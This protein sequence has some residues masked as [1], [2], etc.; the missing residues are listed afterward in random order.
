MPEPFKALGDLYLSVPRSLF[1]QAVEAYGKAIE[2]RPFY[3]DAYAG[4]GDANA[5]KGDLDRAVIAYQ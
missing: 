3:A 1:D 2:L 4:L 5:A